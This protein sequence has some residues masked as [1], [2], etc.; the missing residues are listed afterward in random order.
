M[1]LIWSIDLS[2][3]VKISHKPVYQHLD[4]LF[5][6]S[7]VIPLTDA[8]RWVVFSDLH[9]GDGSSTDDFKPNSQLFLTALQQYYQARDFG[10]VLNGDVEELQRTSLKKIVKQWTPVYEVFDA[11]S[12]KGKLLKTIGNHDIALP[13]QRENP[14]AYDLLEAFRFQYKDQFLFFF[15]GHQASKKFQRHNRL[16]GFTLKYFANPLGIKNYTVSHSSLKQYKIEKRAYHYSAFRKVV[17][18]IGHTHRPLFE[19]QHKVERLKYKIEQ[20]C[21]EY[22]SGP[23]KGSEELAQAIK[24]NKK[25]L[26]K[27]FKQNLETNFQNYVYNTIFHIPCLFNSGCVIGKRG[28]TCL[29]IENGDIRLVHWFDQNISNKYLQKSGYEPEQLPGTDFYRMVIN[30][31]ALDYVFTRIRFLA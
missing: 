6:A 22:V 21:R 17:S 14:H 23:K 24:A 12:R 16:I 10:L 13:V 27:Y 2:F 25:D 4:K 29:E 31:E 26:K 19:S 1:G 11:F 7:P 8:D 28:V 15:H 3:R 9:M 30:Q 20:Q 5:E 18:V